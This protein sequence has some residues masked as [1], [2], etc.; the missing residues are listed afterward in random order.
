MTSMILFVSDVLTMGG[1][2]AAL[3]VCWAL[4]QQRNGLFFLFCC[5]AI[6]FVGLWLFDLALQAGWLNDVQHSLYRRLVGRGLI[7]IGMMGFYACLL[8]GRRRGQHITAD[9]STGE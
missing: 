1:A 6:S 7:G 5:C 4:R 3:M 9:R 2:C 8:H